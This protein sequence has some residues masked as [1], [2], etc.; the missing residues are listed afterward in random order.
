[1]SRRINVICVAIIGLSI[2]ATLA[3]LLLNGAIDRE[4]MFVSVRGELIELYG[5]GLYGYDSVS[6]ALQAKAQDFITLIVGV[7]T[8]IYSLVNRKTLK[9][10]F[11][12]LGLIAYFVYTYTSYVFLSNFNQLFFVY[13]AIVSLSITALIIAIG[14][15]D[16][17]NIKKYYKEKTPTRLLGNFQ[18]I[19]GIMIAFMWI[20]RIKPYF[21]GGL[22]LGLEHYT[23]LVI[24]ALDFGLFIP[25]AIVGGISLKKQTSMGYLLSPM[26]IT[27]ALMLGISILAMT[28]NQFIQ[29]SYFS[30]LETG[31]FVIADII[32]LT[33]FILLFKSI[34]DNNNV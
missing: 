29:N 18:I 11:L 19:V 15:I 34:K 9:G 33:C 25:L 12:F 27:K 13:V 7:P 3:G 5:K 20:G 31:I 21:L 17:T 22:P 24:Q 16:Y 2:L 6:V 28:I 30:A 26:V 23:T 32:I 10:E 14:E 4:L 1:M 8:L